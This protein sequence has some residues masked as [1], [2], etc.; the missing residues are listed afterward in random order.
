MGG[1]GGEDAEVLEEDGEVGGELG[2]RA[3]EVDEKVVGGDEL[4]K[5]VGR[6]HLEMEFNDKPLS[7]AM[8]RAELATIVFCSASSSCSFST[9]ILTS[10]HRLVAGLTLFNV[11]MYWANSIIWSVACGSSA[12][13]R[14]SFWWM[15]SMLTGGVALNH[16][17]VD[18]CS[19]ACGGDGCSGGREMWGI[20]GAFEGTGR[21]S[22]MAGQLFGWLSLQERQ[23]RVLEFSAKTWEWGDEIAG[24]GAR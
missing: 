1:R 6:L 3:G 24:A 15:F 7:G 20:G 22:R 11:S 13:I 23:R 5:R 10:A 8:D 21:Q 16:Q 19:H 14:G 9:R 4:C 12:F 17:G 2:R 18:F